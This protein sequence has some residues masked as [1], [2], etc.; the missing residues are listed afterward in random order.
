MSQSKTVQPVIC[1]TFLLRRPD[2]LK[3]SR[4]TF[5]VRDR[6]GFNA[7]QGPLFRFFW[8][9]TAAS[10]RPW[11]PQKLDRCSR[12]PSSSLLDLCQGAHLVLVIPTCPTVTK[13]VWMCTSQTFQPDEISN[14]KCYVHSQHQ[15]CGLCFP[16]PACCMSYDI[17]MFFSSCIATCLYMMENC[18][19]IFPS[20]P[21]NPHVWLW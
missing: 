6:P 17:P 18:P 2:P 20:M 1:A 15:Y 11:A 19:L 4:K 9:R 16:W 14:I 7:G 12:L 13:P 3:I 5:S 10:S 21:S 8:W